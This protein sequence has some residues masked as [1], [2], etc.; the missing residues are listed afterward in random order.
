MQSVQTHVRDVYLFQSLAPWYYPWSDLI[1]PNLT[2]S[3]TKTPLAVISCIINTVSQFFAGTQAQLAETPPQR[4]E[5]GFMRL[6]FKKQTI[7][8]FTSPI[9]FIALTGNTD[10]AILLNKDTIE[11]DP[12]VFAFKEDST[13]EGTLCMVL[14][15]VRGLLGRPFTFWNTD[16]HIMLCT[17]SQ[18]RCQEA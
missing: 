3:V 6:S 15:I 11:R 1:I 2:G 5:D 10:L 17:H 16:G 18:R 12:M 14:L 8:T 7:I 13:S 4:L 9:S